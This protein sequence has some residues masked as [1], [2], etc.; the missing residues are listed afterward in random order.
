MK[1]HLGININIC[2]PMLDAYAPL[3]PK[4]I[5][6]IGSKVTYGTGGFVNSIMGT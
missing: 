2:Q 3:T 5:Q 1:N 6:Q 4:I